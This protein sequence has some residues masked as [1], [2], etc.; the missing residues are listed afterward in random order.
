M[1]DTIVGKPD[2]FAKKS[3]RDDMIVGKPDGFAT[4]S[5]RDDMIRFFNRNR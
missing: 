3:R 5:R 2:G 1:D 4:K